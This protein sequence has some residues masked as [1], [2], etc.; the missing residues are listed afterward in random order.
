[1]AEPRACALE[2]CGQM[3]EPTRNDAK[4][5]SDLCRAK[6]N[7]A[8]RVA[9][10]DS[11]SHVPDGALAR[12]TAADEPA[13]SKPGDPLAALA[14]RVDDLEAA[15]DLAE[16]ARRSIEG[17]LGLDANQ[18]RALMRAEV[19]AAVAPLVRRVTAVERIA[20]DL[21]ERANRV[22]AETELLRRHD[23]TLN[24]HARQLATLRDEID[25]FAQGVAALIP[26]EDAA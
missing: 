7:K 23:R 18:V 2:E 11:D 20:L 17:R 9:E 26:D 5:H 10:A 19:Q 13:P 6:A 16:S 12:P 15:F 25:T 4:Y 14:V 21:A 8:R 24:Q 22:S 3:F 1:M